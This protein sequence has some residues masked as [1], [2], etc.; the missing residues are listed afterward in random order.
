MDILNSNETEIISIVHTLY[1]IL[2]KQNRSRQEALREL[3]WSRLEQTY[4]S[5]AAS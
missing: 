1:G 2:E 5:A 4:K 3:R